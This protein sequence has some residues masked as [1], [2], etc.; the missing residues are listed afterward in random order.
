MS[1]LNYW[2]FYLILSYCISGRLPS[3]RHSIQVFGPNRFSLTGFVHPLGFSSRCRA[4]YVFPLPLTITGSSFMHRPQVVSPKF[5]D[6]MKH[7][8]LVSHTALATSIDTVVLR[9]VTAGLEFFF[10][11]NRISREHTSAIMNSQTTVSNNIAPNLDRFNGKPS[12]LSAADTIKTTTGC[13]FLNWGI[14][15]EI[16]CD[17]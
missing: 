15:W 7:V 16:R 9:A 12:L 1:R 2:L 3:V 13:K 8:S 5:L 6:L 4:T 11:F 14:L 17:M 10:F